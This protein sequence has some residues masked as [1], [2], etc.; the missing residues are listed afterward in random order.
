VKK[1]T[2]KTK[3]F[4][5]FDEEEREIGEALEKN[6]LGRSADEEE[7]KKKLVQAARAT[8]AKTRHISIRLSEKDLL[9][10]RAKALELGI[11]YQTLVGSILH[12]YA[13]GKVKA[14]F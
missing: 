7:W 5:P 10:L 9:K 3:R 8:M 4:E 13:A 2:D 11:P 1:A 6:A 14:S 12:Q